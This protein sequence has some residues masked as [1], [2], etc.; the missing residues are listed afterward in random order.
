MIVEDQS[1]VVGFLSDPGTYG[2]SEPV[3]VMRTHISE[4]FLAGNRAYKLKRAVRLPY[5]DF[6]TVGLRHRACL[7]EV[8][9]NRITAP[10]L[11]LGIR[12]ITQDDGGGLAFDGT[13][14]HLDTV[15]EMVRFP[16]ECLFDRMALDGRLTPELLSETA[17][18]IARFHKAAPVICRGTGSQNMAEVFTINEAGFRTSSVFSTDEVETITQLFRKRLKD[19]AEVLD[20]RGQAGHIRRCHGDLHLRNICLFDDAPR[21]FDCIDFNSRIATSDVLYDLAFLLMDLW[22]RGLRRFANLVVNRYL[23][24]TQD[25]GGFGLLPFFMATRAAVRAHVTATQASE[26]VGEAA[27]RLSVEARSY[28]DLALDLLRPSLPSL[29]AI[30]GLSGSGKT[31]VSEFIACDIGIG[32]GARIIESDRVR[33]RMH[34]VAPEARLPATAYR[35]EVSEAV[36][37]ELGRIAGRILEQDAPTLVEAVFQRAGDR[38]AIEDVARLAGAPF[39]GIWLEADPSVLWD[40]VSRRAAGPSDADTSVL[41]R[42]LE[43][44][45]A[46]AGWLHIDASGSVEAVS[47]AILAAIGSR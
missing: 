37:H 1:R 5:V 21:L 2:L 6:S 19:H 38:T 31:T 25:D 46:D 44:P 36:Y 20:T 32:P 10:T 47:A 16:Q 30:G 8:A 12:R 29:L 15:V 43:G 9:L 42:Q 18:A 26:A 14:T 45:D 22:H 11:Y 41:A 33:K 28:Y 34:G 27:E 24:E 4:I 13:G 3:E 40:R 35:P 7:E 39:R 23:D 17:R